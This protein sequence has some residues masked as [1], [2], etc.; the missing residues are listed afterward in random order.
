MLLNDVSHLLITTSFN[1]AEIFFQLMNILFS[2]VILA[3]N[4]SAESKRNPKGSYFNK[5]N[6]NESV[7]EK[8]V[9]KHYKRQTKIVCFF[10][11]FYPE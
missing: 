4:Q 2:Y 11:V 7:L 9:I 1:H 10:E 5:K 8:N 6:F 3:Q